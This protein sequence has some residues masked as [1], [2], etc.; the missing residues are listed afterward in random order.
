M[1]LICLQYKSFL[2]EAANQNSLKKYSP[3]VPEHIKKY[4]KQYIQQYYQQ[5]NLVG[6]FSHK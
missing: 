2:Q 1:F 3:K 4:T 5:F 6:C